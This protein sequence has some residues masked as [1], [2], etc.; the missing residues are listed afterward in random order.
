MCKNYT[1]YIGKSAAV[2]LYWNGSMENLG[3]V[4]RPLPIS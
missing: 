2:V 4:S 1:N 3:A